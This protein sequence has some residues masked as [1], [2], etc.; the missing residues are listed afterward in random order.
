MNEEDFGT[1][2]EDSLAGWDAK[3]VRPTVRRKGTKTLRVSNVDSAADSLFRAEEHIGQAADNVFHWKWVVICL[4]NSLYTFALTVAAGSNPHTVMKGDRVVDFLGAVKLCSGVK[5][6]C[7]SIP[8]EITRTQKNSVLW[9][10]KHLRNKFEHFS[11]RNTWW[12]G[13]SGLPN[14][15]IDALEAIKFLALDGGNIVYHTKAKEK[16]IGRS[17]RKSIKIL[18]SSPLYAQDG[19][20]EHPDLAKWK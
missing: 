16:K 1:S 18:R 20:K 10:H 2:F 17:I 4:Q 3:P 19:I 7:H 15:C 6:F 5:R 13:L 14:M 9:L 12:I 11:P 8:F